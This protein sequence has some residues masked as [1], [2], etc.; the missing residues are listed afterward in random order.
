MRKRTQTNEEHEHG[1]RVGA[2]ALASL[3][4]P[5]DIARKRKAS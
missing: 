5:P 3:N 4:P 1:R 2:D